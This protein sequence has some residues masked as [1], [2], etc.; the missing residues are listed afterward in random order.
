MPTQV[1]DEPIAIQ[2]KVDSLPKNEPVD[3]NTILDQES[4]EKK[5]IQDKDIMTSD[6]KVFMPKKSESF[7]NEDIVMPGSTNVEYN[8]DL[9]KRAGSI[10]EAESLWEMGYRPS[11]GERIQSEATK[12]S[13]KN[14]MFTRGRRGIEMRMPSPSVEE[15]KPKAKE[16]ESRQDRNARIAPKGGI[17]FNGNRFYKF[18]APGREKT[19][20]ILENNNW[21]RLNDGEEKW[22]IITQE[23]N[24]KSLN[25][26]HGIEATVPSMWEKPK[27]MFDDSELGQ[28]GKILHERGVEFGGRDVEGADI[29]DKLLT[30]ED[31]VGGDRPSRPSMDRGFEGSYEDLLIAQTD[32]DIKYADRASAVMRNSEQIREKAEYIKQLK[33]EL[34]QEMRGK[35]LYTLEEVEKRKAV[36]PDDP[37]VKRFEEQVNQ[38]YSDRLQDIKD[39]ED[40]LA[41]MVEGYEFELQSAET[42]EKFQELY[43][44][45]YREIRGLDPYLIREM[46]LHKTYG[47]YDEGSIDE[48]KNDM[49]K[50][51]QANNEISRQK[52]NEF[53]N[54]DIDKWASEGRGQSLNEVAISKIK[55]FQS[56][57]KENPELVNG[58][59]P[60]VLID[61]LSGFIEEAVDQQRQMNEIASSGE[62]MSDW[63]TNQ[64]R[65]E[66]EQMLNSGSDFVSE[67]VKS[68]FQRTMAIRDIVDSYAKAGKINI[69]PSE[70]SFDFAENVGE[71]EKAIINQEIQ[72]AIDDYRSAKLEIFSSSTQ[73]IKEKQLEISKLKSEMYSIQSRS[74]SK[75]LSPGDSERYEVIKNKISDLESEIET[76]KLDNNTVLLNDPEEIAESAAEMSTKTARDI[77]NNI[78]PTLSPKEKLDLF[79]NRLKNKT[80]VMSQM[81]NIDKTYISSVT[82]KLKDIA[83]YR[84]LGFNLSPEAEEYYKNMSILRK[85]APIYFNNDWG[86]TELSSGFWSAFMNSFIRTFSPTIADSEGFYNETE[87]L[88]IQDNMIKSLGLTDKSLSKPEMTE[89]IKDRLDV[90]FF[91]SESWG[92]MIGTTTAFMTIMIGTGAG[93]SGA[94]KGG[95][96]LISLFDKYKDVERISNSVKD[97]KRLDDVFRKTLGKTKLGSKLIQPVSVGAN[98]EISGRIV[99]STR[100]NMSFEHGF[101]GVLAGKGVQALAKKIPI[102]GAVDYLQRIFGSSTKK[103]VEAITRFG[104]E[105]KNLH[106]MGTGELFEET[107]QDLVTIYNSELK[108]RGFWD[109]VATRYG[110]MDYAFRHAFASYFMG[111]GF[112]IGADVNIDSYT[113]GMTQEETEV[114]NALVSE[115]AVD[116]SE[117]SAARDVEANKIRSIYDNQDGARVSSEE[118]VGEK[119]V[120]ADTEQRTSEEEVGDGRMVQEEKAEGEVTEKTPESETVKEGSEAKVVSMAERAKKAADVIR[121]E[122]TTSKDAVLRNIAASSI[123]PPKIWDVALEGLAYS[124]ETIGEIIDRV[125]GSE[126]Y[127]G[128]TQRDKARTSRELYR[129]RDE[130]QEYQRKVEEAKGRQPKTIQELDQIVSDKLTEEESDAFGESLLKGVESAKR[131]GY[132]VLAEPLLV[133][134]ADGLIA[135]YSQDLESYNGEKIGVKVHKKKDG[136]I[137]KR[138]SV[139]DD[140]AVNE[141]IESSK[142]FLTVEPSGQE[143]ESVLDPRVEAVEDAE[144]GKA[145]EGRKTKAIA[146]ESAGMRK[147]SDVKE[148]YNNLKQQ[149]A[150]FKKTFEEG[151]KTGKKEGKEQAQSKAKEKEAR[152]E[153]MQKA[154]LDFAREF[155]PKEYKPT[156]T[157]LIAMMNSIRNAKNSKQADKAMQR[158]LDEVAKFEEQSRKQ[159]ISDIIKMIKDKKTLLKKEGNRWK[160]KIPPAYQQQFKDLL[161]NIEVDSL[162]DMTIEEATS[163]YET[164]KNAI[165]EGKVVQ[166]ELDKAKSIARKYNIGKALESLHDYNTGKGR[167]RQKELKTSYDIR[168][169]LNSGQPIIF[170]GMVFSSNSA[171]D[172]YLKDNDISVDDIANIGIKGLN[173]DPTLAS[174][175]SS[176]GKWFEELG[177]ARMAL[178]FF[179]Q[180][181]QT[182]ENRLLALGKN[183]PQ[184]RE[185]TD[186]LIDKV[187]DAHYDMQVERSKKIEKIKSNLQDVFGGKTAEEAYDIASKFTSTNSDITINVGGSELN[188]TY[189]LVAKALN[190]SKQ[191]ASTIYKVGENHFATEEKALEESAKTGNVVEEVGN[192]NPG[193]IRQLGD[194]NLNDGIE[195][196]S[197]IEELAETETKIQEYADFFPDTYTEFREDYNPLYTEVHNREMPKKDQ[198]YVP[199]R[200]ARDGEYNRANSDAEIMEALAGN[201]EGKNPVGDVMSNHLKD[202]KPNGKGNYDIYTDPLVE[203]LGYV[204][205]MEHTR[206]LLPVAKSYTELINPLTST[207]I[208]KKLGN[209]NVDKGSRKLAELNQHM[210]AVLSGDA[211]MWDSSEGI[212][213]SVLQLKVLGTLALKWSAIPKQMTSFS[214]FIGAGNMDGVTGRHWAMALGKTLAKTG[215]F[216]LSKEE[217]DVIKS[218]V[219]SPFVQERL[220]NLD[221][222]VETRKLNNRV[223][224]GKANPS[225]ISRMI[226][227]I[228]MSPTKYGDILGVLTGGIPYTMATYYKNTGDLNMNHEEALDDALRKFV[229]ASKKTQQSTRSDV[230]SNYQRSKLGRIFST[231]TTS[232][233]AAMANLLEGYHIASDT[234]RPAKERARGVQKMLYYSVANALFTGVA[235]GAFVTLFFLDEDDESVYVNTKTGERVKI[236]DLKSERASGDF[237]KEGED[238]YLDREMD[239][240]EYDLIMG[241]IQSNLDGL[242]VM[243]KAANWAINVATDKKAFNNVPLIDM[244]GDIT[245]NVVGPYL[246]NTGKE[247]AGGASVLEAMSYGYEEGQAEKALDAIG[248]DN[249]IKIFTD[250]KKLLDNEI[251]A[252]TYIMGSKDFVDDKKED[253]IFNAIY[254]YDPKAPEINF[255]KF[256]ENIAPVVDYDKE[257]GEARITTELD[258]A[259]AVEGLQDYSKKLEEFNKDMSNRNLASDMFTEEEAE[260]AG[261]Y[262]KREALKKEKEER[263]QGVERMI[264][265]AQQ[266]VKRQE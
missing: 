226:V 150:E 119:S 197:Q 202:R 195:K 15:E 91:T 219:K 71:D 147:P 240:A 8:Q 92:G 230:L 135:V 64:K 85:L 72:K 179:S 26:Y 11:D 20:Y 215:T 217:A 133:E 99:G 2:P 203:M 93:T 16:K 163:L 39:E 127:K 58:D 255:D 57:L 61:Q 29:E 206:A 56:L 78:D 49:Q 84:D 185:Y 253:W 140:N 228:S 24:I 227:Q 80:Q 153:E 263:S 120:E 105:A 264:R 207:E 172:S 213:N 155:I 17:E 116:F 32:W 168:E 170:D 4:E 113:E 34:D 69:D 55:E 200:R 38:M 236:K 50:A 178:G 159:V 242:G 62:K 251:D 110:D 76:E 160:G 36:S 86:V 109:E 108:T 96:A 25:N 148:E 63:L 190:Q 143:I 45:E 266:N 27:L 167:S 250:G 67:E 176:K 261:G 141:A 82:D 98:M 68:V 101:L 180:A 169:H 48:F 44:E 30:E 118:Q 112:G 247:I 265:Q 14:L 128:L 218:V 137:G 117:A 149:I 144:T 103:A 196:I 70:S 201:K 158:I 1:S 125:Q 5:E 229:K 210:A 77:L 130:L 107:M 90:P 171:L 188:L 13:L 40:E 3:E 114:F 129:R 126:W 88:A 254:G 193:I 208:A 74:K 37:A 111:V 164:L 214:H 162:A 121:S 211:Q 183:I 237:V 245:A 60:S 79:Y 241:T 42:A 145:P 165:Q 212:F 244:I 175:L 54:R 106:Y 221:L 43:P 161:S 53:I 252:W 194:G 142:E 124:V 258:K 173:L 192:Y 21:Y 174:K 152:I 151:F 156:K 204:S 123:I 95:K 22:Q 46:V 65:S 51:F 10:N 235:S 187:D 154:I 97:I 138:T 231:F 249:A 81:Y 222:D 220:K 31:L 223:M 184:L 7:S 246:T 18:P 35:G 59:N 243:G 181:P 83:D 232:Q 257:T 191:E 134:T 122:K 19:L 238:L 256:Q 6:I 182:L 234:S 89:A 132:E 260:K 131:K 23:E 102:S 166:K 33:S 248:V 28:A 104:S 12:D 189:G 136:S 47:M 199:L 9:S 115:L 52:I 225:E 205:S 209:G 259:A 239:K 177:K 233:V 157:K 75:S 41:S 198:G 66:M 73:K 146:E 139:L 216:Q 224:A 94:I 262:A 186:G 87:M 100:E